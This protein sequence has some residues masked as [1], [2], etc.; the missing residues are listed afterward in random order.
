M[1]HSQ[2]E[3]DDKCPG[4]L[5]EDP[6]GSR[7]YSFFNEQFREIGRLQ[8][9]YEP[10]DIFIVIAIETMSY[11]RSGYVLAPH[12][13]GWIDRVNRITIKKLECAQ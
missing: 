11:T 9:R 6:Y 10:T 13:V 2:T 12:A 5:C 1:K 7:L 3:S 8:W 4:D